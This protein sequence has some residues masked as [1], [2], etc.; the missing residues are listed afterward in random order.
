MI[1]RMFIT[2]LIDKFS[3]LNSFL[4]MKLARKILI[5]FYTCVAKC[6]LSYKLERL[7]NR[8]DLCIIYK[9]SSAPERNE[10]VRF[11]FTLL[12]HASTFQMAGLHLRSQQLSLLISF[13]I[14]H[15]GNLFALTGLASKPS[16][17]LQAMP[18]ILMR[19]SLLPSTLQRP[20]N[21]FLFSIVVRCHTSNVFRCFRCLFPDLI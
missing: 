6:A 4:W 11:A 8:R 18:P 2:K 19:L 10:L 9:H 3:F 20:H 13:Y 5:I 17:I 16:D 14:L 21:T 15:P 1:S 12:G 7:I